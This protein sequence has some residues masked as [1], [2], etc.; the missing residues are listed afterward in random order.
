ML[1]ERCS[2]NKGTSAHGQQIISV[3][4]SLESTANEPLVAARGNM[5]DSCYR[6]LGEVGGQVGQLDGDKCSPFKMPGA[7][8]AESAYRDVPDLGHPPE[9]AT[10]GRDR[11]AA[12]LQR[13]APPWLGTP[14]GETV[15]S[16]D[17]FRGRRVVYH[18][19]CF[20][21]T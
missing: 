7:E 10:S 5:H 18:G 8:H 13:T 17:R 15:L 16:V 14:V 19:E 6:G 12:Y 20:L 9:I 2:V 4:W 11:L 21:L 3:E 1:C